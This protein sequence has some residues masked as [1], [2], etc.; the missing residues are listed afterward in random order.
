MSNLKLQFEKVS[1]A[2]FQDLR[3]LVVEQA[4]HH[5]CTYRGKDE[6]FITALEQENPVARVLYMRDT[7]TQTPLG[8]ILY[9]HTY[10]L[11][12]QDFYIEDIL[13]SRK[14]RSHGVGL[15]LIDA[16][17]GLGQDQGIDHISWVVS[18]NN[19]GAI[20][21]YKERM[22]ATAQPYDSYDCADLYKNPI[23]DLPN[24]ETREV[25]E[26]DMDL[27]ESYLGSVSFLTEK[28]MKNIR[29]ASNAHHAKVYMTF[30]SDGTPMA[31]GI[32]NSNF[33][34]FRTVYGFKFEVMELFPEQVENSVYALQAMTS[35]VVEVGHK[36][37][38]TGHLNL[39][40]DQSSLVQRQLVQQIGAAPLMMSDHPNSFLDLYAIG[41]D[42]IYTQRPENMIDMGQGQSK[43]PDKGIKGLS[44]DI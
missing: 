11:K 43:N 26:S 36:T 40:V 27:L 44:P 31:V 2:N 18:R 19:D 17:K 3:S 12:G 5:A 28:K 13:V 22:K 38:H 34:S 25:D 9:N 32:T 6:S 35:H 24:Y 8:Y 29:M 21:F 33:S 42:V 23:I 16:L 37:E 4:E 10:G 15:S 14:Q 39:F 7:A 30:G 20:R 1:R 41:R